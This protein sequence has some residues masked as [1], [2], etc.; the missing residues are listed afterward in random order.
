VAERPSSG[1]TGESGHAGHDLER[2]VAL[3]D[4]D[5][6]AIERDAAVAQ[7]EACSAC[8]ALLTDLRA[9]AAATAEMPVPTR[10]REFTLTPAMAAGLRPAVDGEPARAGARLMGE[11][12]PA[13]S[14]HETH[15]R[16]LVASLVDRSI[17][18]PERARA[19][20]QLRAC[21][22]CA[23][24][25]AELVALSVATR[26]MPVPVRT[27]DFALTPADADRLRVR[28]WRRLVAAIG[29]SRDA[30]SRPL[31]LGFTTLGLAGLLLSSVS[32]PFGG[33]TSGDG[34]RSVAAPAGENGAGSVTQE[35]AAAASGAPSLPEGSGPDMVAAAPSAAP[36]EA[37]QL[38]PAASPG[39]NPPEPLFDGGESSPLPGEPPADRS[40]YSTALDQDGSF[41]PSPMFLVAAVLLVIGLGLFGIRWT[42][43]RLG[44]G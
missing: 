31:A 24:L 43:R 20:A 39:E 4:G 34:L 8:R 26:A 40:L 10:T 11:M 7:S 12:N 13:T 16:L 25:H 18:E 37:A 22:A 36:S 21:R 19:E 27:R 29:S 44:D 5:L 38:A 15:D 14:R 32:L 2:I 28:R 35:F 6:P 3:L 9:L 1:P 42:A 17:T 41:A 23:E 30:F 33:A